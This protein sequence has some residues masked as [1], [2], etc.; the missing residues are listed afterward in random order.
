MGIQYYLIRQME[1]KRIQ[2]IH[3]ANEYGLT[4][5]ETVR[6]SQELDH[7]MNLYR[8]LTVKKNNNEVYK[9]VHYMT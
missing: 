9:E 3:S 1:A 2:M 8:R 6:Y 5:K 7:L 4:S